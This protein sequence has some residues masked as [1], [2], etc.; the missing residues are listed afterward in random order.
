MPGTGEIV[1]RATLNSGRLRHCIPIGEYRNRAY[2]VKRDVLSD[3][4]GL[5]VKDGFLQ[6]S[7]RLPRFLH[8]ERFL[9]WFYAHAG[10]LIP[11]NNPPD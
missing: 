10:E 7:A 4:G 3:W 11:F 6:R 1:V 9:G 8:P 2:R 5:S